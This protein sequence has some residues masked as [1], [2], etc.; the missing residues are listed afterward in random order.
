MKK[1]ELEITEEKT[2]DGVRLILKGQANSGTAGKLQELLQKALDEGQ[3]NII[4]N[5]MRV[6]FL[7]S[8][9]IRVILKTYQEVHRAGGK[10]GIEMPSQNVRNVLGQT[11]LDEILIK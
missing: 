9:G 11:A 6:V 3:K 2:P 1:E 5:M 10:F 7:S 4:L 8:A